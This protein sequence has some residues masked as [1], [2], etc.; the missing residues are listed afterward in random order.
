MAQ[1]IKFANHAILKAHNNLFNQQEVDTLLASFTRLTGN[2]QFMAT[3]YDT[4]N[5]YHVTA[6]KAKSDPSLL[7]IEIFQAGSETP[8]RFYIDQNNNRILTDVISPDSIGSSD[9]LVNDLIQSSREATFMVEAESPA[10][11]GVSNLVRNRVST[12]LSAQ[13]VPANLNDKDAQ[14]LLSILKKLDADFGDL[15][16]SRLQT[17]ANNNSEDSDGDSQ[18]PLAA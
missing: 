4:G 5:R 12:T 10:V 16:L 3:V 9:P 8:L 15:D 1:L 17:A 2:E 7:Q 18:I 11:E 13:Q 6:D 14:V